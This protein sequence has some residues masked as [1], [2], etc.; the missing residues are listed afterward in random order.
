MFGSRKYTPLPTSANPQRRRAG[1]GV[2]SWKRWAMVGAAVSLVIILGYSQVPSRKGY[3]E[4]SEDENAESMYTPDL[5]VGGGDVDMTDYSSPPF[6]P[7][8]AGGLDGDDEGEAEGE[9]E[10]EEVEE[11]DQMVHIQP[12]DEDLD[13]NV[14]ENPDDN[15]EFVQEDNNDAEGGD[16]EEGEADEAE[17]ND[18][19]ADDSTDEDHHSGS[20]HDPLD[21]AAE[22]AEEAEPDF[23]EPE[24]EVEAEKSDNTLFGAGASGLPTSFETDPN[25]SSTTAC[26]E[27]HGDKPLVQYALTIDAGSTGSRIHVYKFHNCGPSPELEYE[28]FKMLNPGL[29]AFA[30][31]PSAAAAS[32]DPLL[33]EAMRVVPE[34]LH[35]CTPVEVKATAGLRLLGTAES[36]AILDEVRN[37]LKDNFPFGVGDENSVEIMDGKD[38]GV[39][40]WITANYLA[41]KIGEG[42]DSPDTLAVMDLGGASTQIVFEPRFPSERDSLLEGEHKYSLQFGGKE[43]TLYQ[44]SYL[45]YGLMRARRSI[46]NLVAFTFSFGQGELEW[47]NMSEDIMVPNPCLSHGSTRRVELDPPGRTAVNVT[48]HGGNGGFDACNRV[49]QLVMAKDA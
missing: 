40:A 46:H 23:I 3:S 8:G 28:T 25:P 35:S 12:I 48:M 22:K 1:G 42:V 6:R 21:P 43:F 41:Q 2:S 31:D 29:S 47:D 9:G 20:P 27:P 36:D 30:S 26:D 11:G 15:I 7:E 34:Q 17:E 32:L 18:D 49:V 44:H 14:Q 24:G 37:R 38:E 39:Y 33:E 5:E 4:W 16:A 10:A 45:G 19:S 13:A